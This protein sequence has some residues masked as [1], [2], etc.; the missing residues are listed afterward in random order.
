M[1]RTLA[2]VPA[3]NE[4]TRIAPVIRGLLALGLPVLVV[5]DGSRDATA[6][7]AR[8]AGAR[9]LRKANGGKGTA[10][11]AGAAWALAQGFDQA[12]FLDG[13]GQHDPAE[14][15]RLLAA[16]SRLR[17]AGHRRILVIGGRL[18][19]LARQPTYRRCFNRL[20]SLVVTWF[21]G[22]RIVD[23]QSGYRLCDPAVLLA[24]PTTGCRYDLE[25]EACI[26]AA[27]A[28]VAVAEVPISVIYNDK[29]SGVHPVFDTARFFI[30]A[31]GATLAS[32][33]WLRRSAPGNARSAPAADV[34]ATAAAEQA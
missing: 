20:S 5:D 2:V 7:V 33:P 17:A 23:S 14:A 4:A 19:C 22:R 18:L 31:A 16:G 3:F 30:A 24:L 28:G 9:V 1:I 11:R 25:T 8:D 32:R 10:I 26:L 6:D 21:S 12:L 34:P 13:D 29:V 27:R 15:V